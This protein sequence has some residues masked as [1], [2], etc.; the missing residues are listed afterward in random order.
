MIGNK[1]CFF[2]SLESTN[3]FMKEHLNE[4]KNGDLVC[5]KRQINGRGRRK[6]RWVSLEGNLFI[7]FLMRNQEHSL[8]DLIKLVSLSVCD[9]LN[10]RG[11][12]SMIKYPNDILVNGKKICGILIERSIGENDDFVV[13]VGLNV[14]MDDFE[15]INKEATSIKLVSGLQLDYRDALSDFI[16]SF[17]ENLLKET[18]DLYKEYLK[19]SIVLGKTIL[20]D[21]T[22][23]LVKNIEKDGT[24][25]LNCEGNERLVQLSETILEE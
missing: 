17:N 18:E 19:R 6:N 15:D 10:T 7:S 12:K 24:M 23:C 11:I 14:L 13:G 9:A 1:V 4:Y 5:A 2:E 16:N 8:F 22:R 20:H 21:E 3:T 25:V